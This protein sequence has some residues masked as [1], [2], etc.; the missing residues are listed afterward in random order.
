[1]K[2]QYLG[3]VRDAFK[4]DLLHWICTKSSPRFDKL[5]FVPML[6]PDIEKSNEGQVPHQQFECRD[7]IRPFLD[8]LKKEPR[9]LER[10]IA[11]GSAEYGSPEFNVSIFPPFPPTKHIGTGKQRADYWAGFEPKKLENAVVFFDPDKG[12]E[13]KTQHGTKW[14]RHSELKNFLS[15]LPETS[16]AVV[17]QHR[18][19]LRKWDDLFADLK[20]KLEY[21]DTAV[22]A[23][24]GNLSFVAMAGN[25]S[26][27]RS[28]FATI[29]G[30]AKEHRVV[31]H[32]V[33]RDIRA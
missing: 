9:S 19:R 17:Y 15:R 23:Y 5:V 31:R 14:V 28:I 25:A 2:L 27:G 21:A 24:E 11:L 4:W 26:A 33:L 18:P 30:Y 1:M 7:F 8:S 32:T 6:T 10:I 16:V 13:T 12:F 20:D 3:D 22:A 29:K